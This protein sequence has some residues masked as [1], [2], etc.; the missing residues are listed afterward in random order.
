MS[1]NTKTKLIHLDLGRNSIGANENLLALHP[2]WISGCSALASYLSAPTCTLETLILDWNMI[3]F[4]SAV[5]LAKSFKKNNSVKVL[6]LSYNGIG[7]EGGEALGDALH[8]NSRLVSVNISHNN[9]SPRACFTITTGIRCCPQLESVDISNNPIGEYG[10][11][12]LMILN[13]QY[14]DRVNVTIKECN[15]KVKDTTCRFDILNPQVTTNCQ[16]YLMHHDSVYMFDYCFHLLDL[17]I[18]IQH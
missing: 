10:A 8:F 2:D 15:L 4:T 16:S 12:A 14:G 3:R 5:T 18:Y 7:V 6:D 13:T 11:R 9:I 1:E 17:L